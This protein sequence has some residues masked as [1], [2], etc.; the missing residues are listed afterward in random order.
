M[1]KKIALKWLVV[2]LFFMFLTACSG[3][4]KVSE[5]MLPAEAEV[6]TAEVITSPPAQ[7]APVNDEAVVF[8][9]MMDRMMADLRANFL[10]Q[11]LMSDDKRKAD[12]KFLFSAFVSEDNYDVTTPLGRMI[13]DALASRMQNTG[14]QVIEVRLSRSMRI[15]K[16]F[17]MLAM[18]QDMQKL[19][20]EHQATFMITGSYTVTPQYVYVLAR[21]I[22][23][24]SQVIY[25]SSGVWLPRSP[26]VNYLLDYRQPTVKVVPAD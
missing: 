13:G 4:E 2:G 17:G 10:D 6:E 23:N 22:G 20:S 1:F 24:T 5:P 3:Y 18:S 21:V 11:G 14:L 15:H 12:A 16:K 8:E 19:F 9:S 25:A 26:M 7:P